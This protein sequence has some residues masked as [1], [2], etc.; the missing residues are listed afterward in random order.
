MAPPTRHVVA[1]V[2]LKG[3]KNVKMPQKTCILEATKKGNE[4]LKYGYE[5]LKHGYMI[6]K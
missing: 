5:L 2:V 4:C 1:F 3:I 6:A